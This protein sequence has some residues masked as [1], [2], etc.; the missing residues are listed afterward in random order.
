VAFLACKK[1]TDFFGTLETAGAIAPAVLL[2]HKLYASYV[3]ID[4]MRLKTTGKCDIKAM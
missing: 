1:V 2:G 4:T 3:R